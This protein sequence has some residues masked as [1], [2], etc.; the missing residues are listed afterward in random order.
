VHEGADATAERGTRL[1][2]RAWLLI[3]GWVAPVV[4][5]EVIDEQ[6]P[7]P[8]WLVSARRPRE[9]EQAIAKAKLA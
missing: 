9:L 1:D 3:R 5:I 4:K 6:D 2:A 8:Y 7:T